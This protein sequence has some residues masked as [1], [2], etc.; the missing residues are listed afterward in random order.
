MAQVIPKRAAPPDLRRLLPGQQGSH[1]KRSKKASSTSRAAV[2]SGVLAP[3]I[4]L[5]VASSLGIA[6]PLMGAGTASAFLRG[7]PLGGSFSSESSPSSSEWLYPP[8][9]FV[10]SLRMPYPYAN[11]PENSHFVGCP[12]SVG[13]PS[14]INDTEVHEPIEIDVND[15]LEPSRTDKR[16]NWSH[17]EDVILGS[18]NITFTLK[19]NY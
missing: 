14:P 12:S 7:M 18:N 6:G 10:N 1:Q 16:L 11:C 15:T 13:T 3:P 19:I 2:N 9:G 5:G 8:G 4:A 17:D